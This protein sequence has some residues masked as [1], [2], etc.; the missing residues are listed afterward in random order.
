LPT[1]SWPSNSVDALVAEN[2][3]LKQRLAAISSMPSRSQQG[4]LAAML[5]LLPSTTT[6]A[7]LTAS[8]GDNQGTVCHQC[9]KN[10]KKKKWKFFLFFFASLSSHRHFAFFL[11]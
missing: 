5:P 10:K 3:L 2:K 6:V 8:A 4:P 1:F 7:N 11:F 9:K